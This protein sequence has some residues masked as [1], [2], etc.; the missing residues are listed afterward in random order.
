MLQN[1]GLKRTA[2]KQANLTLLVIPDA[3]KQATRLSIPWWFIHGVLAFMLCTSAI[4]LYF[5]F[6]Y[7]DAKA[8]LKQLEFVKQVNQAQ[9]AQISGLQAKTKV[10]QEKIETV[11]KLD[12]EVRAMVGLQDPAAETKETA[13]AQQELRRDVAYLSSRSGDNDLFDEMAAEL[14]EIEAKAELQSAKLAELKDDVAKKLDYLAALPDLWPAKGKISSGFGMRKSPFNRYRTEFH[15]GIDINGN[16][17]DPV[18]AAGS[19]VV[20]YAGRKPIWGNIIV[21]DHGYGYKSYYAHNSALLVEEKEHVEK[22][23]LIA[24]VGSTGRS[25]GSHL[26]F[27]VEKNGN[28]ID[29]LLVLSKN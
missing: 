17:G 25:T 2:K 16:T 27:G 1:I 12:Q 3:K 29:P 7:F 5:T 23:Q 24:K 6:G 18:K 9:A 11:D 15:N 8:E 10:L 21:L 14:A 20:V 22:G 13:Q 4:G 28:F 26:H 19:G